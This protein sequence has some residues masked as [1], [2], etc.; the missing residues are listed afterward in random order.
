VCRIVVPVP[1]LPVAGFGH[2][3]SGKLV[4][5][6]FTLRVAG[7]LWCLVFAIIAESLAR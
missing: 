3:S 2:G 7:L 4:F 5:S 1:A 6:L